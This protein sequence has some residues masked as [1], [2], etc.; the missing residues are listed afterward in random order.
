VVVGV[1]TSIEKFSPYECG[2][3][4][5]GDARMVFEIFY[6]LIAILFLIFD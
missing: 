2:F 4:P 6:Y 3:E 1:A 5:V